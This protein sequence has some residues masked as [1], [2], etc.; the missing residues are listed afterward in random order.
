MPFNVGD[1][2][3][4]RKTDLLRGGQAAKVMEVL[5]PCAEH[6]RIREYLVEFQSP[7]QRFLSSDRFLF[8]IYREEEL[9]G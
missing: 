5:P 6:G 3:K 1:V 8:C 4:V 7:P 2:V 9:I